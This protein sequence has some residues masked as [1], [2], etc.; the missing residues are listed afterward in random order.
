MNRK[1]LIIELYVAVFTLSIMTLYAGPYNTNLL[2]NPALNLAG[3][4]GL[5]QMVV[6]AGTCG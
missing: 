6:V 3:I 1:T 2:S 4:P 5:A